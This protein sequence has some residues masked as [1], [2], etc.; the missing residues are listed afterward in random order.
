MRSVFTGL[1][2]FVSYL[3]H[4]VLKFNILSLCLSLVVA[5]GRIFSLLYIYIHACISR[6][7]LLLI[8]LIV[9][10]IYSVVQFSA[11]I[12]NLIVLPIR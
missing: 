9:V 10:G 7:G 2:K 4:G 1:Q 6:G 8:L 11:I 3:D 5:L 12:T